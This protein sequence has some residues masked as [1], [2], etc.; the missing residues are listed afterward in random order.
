MKEEIKIRDALLALSQIQGPHMP[1]DMRGIWDDTMKYLRQ[2]SS[3]QNVHLDFSNQQQALTPRLTQ[4]SD[5]VKPKEPDRLVFG[6]Y[7][8]PREAD[9]AYDVGGFVDASNT[10]FIIREDGSIDRN[11]SM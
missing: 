5:F 11:D 6:H 7:H 9:P 1:E 10:F 2:A 8:N 4:F 3:E